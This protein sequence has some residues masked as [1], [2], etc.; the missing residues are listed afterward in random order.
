M[1]IDAQIDWNLIVFCSCFLGI[2]R[3]V[4]IAEG[5]TPS[6][7]VREQTVQDTPRGSRHTPHKVCMRFIRFDAL[8][9]FLYLLFCENFQITLQ[10]SLCWHLMALMLRSI[11]L[12][13][14]S[15]FINCS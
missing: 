9:R 10:N 7:V 13:Y 15:R 3:E 5:S 6:A 8:D 2:G 14:I 4:G 1:I 11:A 12:V